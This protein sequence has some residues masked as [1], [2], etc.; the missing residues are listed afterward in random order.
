MSKK[1]F[2]DN[3]LFRILRFFNLLEPEYNILSIQKLLM[4]IMIC[5]L[6]YTIFYMP[7]N[8]EMVLTVV[9]VNMATLLNYSYRRWIQ[10]RRETTGKDFPSDDLSGDN[11]RQTYSK[12]ESSSSTD[13]NRG[14]DSPD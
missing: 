3:L 8:L 5:L 9:G 2:D 14:I 13:V 6:V 7:Q 12:Y 1:Y 10:Y 4:W 11:Y